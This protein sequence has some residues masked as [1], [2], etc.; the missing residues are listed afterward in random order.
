[1]GAS[2]TVRMDEFEAKVRLHQGVLFVGILAH[3]HAISYMTIFQ[4]LE[5]ETLPASSILELW[6][7]S[8]AQVIP[9]N[10]AGFSSVLESRFGQSGRKASKWDD[11]IPIRQQQGSHMGLHL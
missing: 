5:A 4:N 2:T 6:C 11:F 9:S 7:W 8:R 1:M 3:P 10:R